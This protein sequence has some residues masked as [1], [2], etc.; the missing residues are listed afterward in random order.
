MYTDQYAKLKTANNTG[1]AILEKASTFWAVIFIFDNPQVK[2]YLWWRGWFRKTLSILSILSTDTCFGTEMVSPLASLFSTGL[3]WKKKDT[4]IKKYCVRDKGQVTLCYS[5]FI[6][7]FS[8]SNC[9][10]ANVQFIWYLLECP[11]C[12]SRFEKQHWPLLF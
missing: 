12:C 11:S 9:F 4:R 6:S 8:R 2:Q 10:I 7:Y 1:K 3:S 5:S